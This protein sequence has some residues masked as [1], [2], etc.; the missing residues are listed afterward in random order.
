[1]TCPRSHG[2]RLPR[3]RFAIQ[4][5][6]PRACVLSQ[7]CLKSHCGT[8]STGMENS[9]TQNVGHISA[10]RALLVLN[11]YGTLRFLSADYVLGAKTGQAFLHVPRNCLRAL[12]PKP[13]Q[14]QSPKREEGSGSCWDH[15]QLWRRI[16]GDTE[17]TGSDAHPFMC[18]ADAGQEARTTSKW[19]APRPEQEG[20]KEAHSTDGAA[21]VYRQSL[22]Q[23]AAGS[24]GGPS[25]PRSETALRTCVPCTLEW[26][27]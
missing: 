27:T 8:I 23:R 13:L 4:A 24:D 12:M 2:F 3:L 26:R 19:R 14:I 6:G 21:T 7:L 5:V 15:E 10:W 20:T 11:V 9:V 22:G 18:R 16:R 25:R 1:M 17:G